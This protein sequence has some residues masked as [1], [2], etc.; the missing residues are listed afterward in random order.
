MPKENKKQNDNEVESITAVIRSDFIIKEPKKKEQNVVDFLSFEELIKIYP[1]IEKSIQ[2]K[3]IDSPLIML[4]SEAVKGIKEHISW[5]GKTRN[6][7][8]EQGGILIGKPYSIDGQII[9]IVEY[10]IPADVTRAS[11]AY[12]VMGTDTWV[13]MLDT[14]DNLYKEKGLYIIGWF[15]THPNMLSV[16]MSATDMGTQ[17]AFFNQPWH[18]AI[19]LNP[20][21][22]LIASFYSEKAISCE[23]YFDDFQDK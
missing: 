5:G 15:H 20:Q 13:K 21:K 10:I 4:S 17:K 1:F 22:K 2:K 11:G 14:Y 9:G 8:Y 18:F 6:N 19:V 23:Y 7:V 16:F 3:G 12:L